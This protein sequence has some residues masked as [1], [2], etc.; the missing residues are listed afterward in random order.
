[1]RHLGDLDN[2]Q[3]A[4]TLASYLLVKG[5]ESHVDDSGS[6]G[7]EIWVKDE[8][9]IDEAISAYEEFQQNPTD[10]KYAGA[11]A[12]AKDI[13][14]E[15]ER[16]SKEIKKRIVTAGKFMQPKKPRLT[17]ALI[18]VCVVVGLMTNLGEVKRDHPIYKALQFTSI[19]N[20]TFQEL[21]P[22]LSEP[23]RDDI[24]LRTASLMRG[25]VWR[26]FTPVL[27]HYSIMHIAFNMWMFFQF[28]GLLERRYN[29]KRLGLLVLLCAAIPNFVQCVVPEGL[30]GSAAAMPEGSNH[31]ITAVGGMSG[32]VYGLFGYVWMKSVFDR[33]FG[34]RIPDS[35]IIIMM[36]WL[37]GC[38][39]A[40]TLAQN[41]IRFFPT[42]VANWAHGVGLLVGLV[43]GYLHSPEES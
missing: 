15:Q 7:A 1:M 17:I 9:R 6:S 16:K 8:D 37:F 18:V 10:S 36:V 24:R 32:V 26:L 14:R 29:W 25:Q 38:I 13:R 2:L 40:E 12:V 35:S 3:Q 21:A 27:I 30:G 33:G 5:I 23:I 4:K 22:S 20:E 28:G 19:D 31:I 11:I 34:F 42:N 39:F 41:G 43:A